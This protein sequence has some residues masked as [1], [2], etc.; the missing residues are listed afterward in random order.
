[1]ARSQVTFSKRENEKKRAQRKKDKAEK[2]EERKANSD[3]GKELEDMM[4]YVDQ[5]GNLVSTPPD[6]KEKRKIKAEDIEL[7]VPR[8]REA[9]P[10]D[11]IRRGTVTFYNA[12]KGYGFI[13][14]HETQESI[15]VHANGL[16]IDIS[17]QDRVSFETVKGAKGL[18]A[19]NVR[20]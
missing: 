5:D 15:F 8:Q 6:P 2:R 17:E 11:L 18:Q 16:Q 3:K 10:E 4:V 9:D 14:D 7:G 19:V 12:A 20:K 13:R 1:M